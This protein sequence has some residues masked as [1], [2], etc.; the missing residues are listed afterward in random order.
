MLL[1]ILRGRVHSLV[2][3]AAGQGARAIQRGPKT[4]A[5]DS[6]EGFTV[7]DI[8]AQRLLVKFVDTD[9]K[10]RCETEIQ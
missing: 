9:G 3:A 5:V 4:L 8:D 2:A 7:F 1:P 6:F 10:I